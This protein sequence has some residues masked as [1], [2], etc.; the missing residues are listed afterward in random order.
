MNEFIKYDVQELTLLLK[1]YYETHRFIP[2]ANVTIETKIGAEG[3]GNDEY[4]G[5]TILAK[6]L[7]KN[8]ING[9]SEDVLIIADM[10]RF[11][12]VVLNDHG[13]DVNSIVFNAGIHENSVPTGIGERIVKKPYFDGITVDATKIDK[14]K[15]SK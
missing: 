12:K 15:H 3:S 4:D 8:K 6:V 2:V 5:V 14:M 13:Y 10:K 7:Y 11:T 9:V 1:E